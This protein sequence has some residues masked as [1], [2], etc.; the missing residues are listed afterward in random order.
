MMRRTSRGLA[1]PE[2]ALVIGFSLLVILGA[3]QMTLIG[4]NQVA[5][6][7]AAFVAA[8]TAAQNPAANGTTAALSVFT[9]LTAG[10]FT[11]PSPQP[12]RRVQV[13]VQ[14]SVG[15]FTL[16]PGGRATFTVQGADIEY[17]PAQT[18][19]SPAPYAFSV[20]ATLY[21][22]CDPTGN[23]SLP[24]SHSIYLAQNVGTGHGNGVNGIFAEWQC[25]QKYFASV[26]WPATRPANYQ[27]IA[28]TNLDPK[29]N[30]SAEQNID[31]WDH[32]SN[33]CS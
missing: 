30:G 28:N 27:A 24:S 12:T 3:A 21:N 17:A 11:T 13:S 23:C 4:Y 31:S 9:Q 10:A 8:H 32:G 2:T 18:Y 7:G 14:R 22:Y 6:D 20:T 33:N 1:L 19:A 15:G 25:H 5:V 26:N 29:N 16:L